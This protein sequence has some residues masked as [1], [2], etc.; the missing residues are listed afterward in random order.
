MST[1]DHSRPMEVMHAHNHVS[2]DERHGISPRAC[3]GRPHT[4]QVGTALGDTRDF[5]QLSKPWPCFLPFRI[6]AV[7]NSAHGR[8]TSGTGDGGGCGWA[9]PTQPSLITRKLDLQ[10]QPQ[11]YLSASCIF[12][13][14]PPPPDNRGRSAFVSRGGQRIAGDQS[15]D[16]NARV[17]ACAH[18]FVDGADQSR[19]S[20][21][22]NGHWGLGVM[23]G[24]G[25]CHIRVACDRVEMKSW[26]GIEP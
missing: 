26:L 10:T 5:T 19:R 12:L 11:G 16:D 20:P 1:Y 3:V 4:H 22:A 21:A 8:N 7:D 9:S 2:A 14:P 13:H 6:F 15:R 23:I 25:A 17:S 18:L 24:S